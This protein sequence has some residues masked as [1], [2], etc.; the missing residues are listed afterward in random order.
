VTLRDRPASALATKSCVILVLIGNFASTST[1]TLSHTEHLSSGARRARL[2]ALCFF[3]ASAR[4]HARNDP[5]VQMGGVLF[6]WTSTSRGSSAR[7]MLA[8]RS[9]SL[10]LLHT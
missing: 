2:A 4:L 6:I 3:T 5:H 1:A 7:R 10:V 8:H 9:A